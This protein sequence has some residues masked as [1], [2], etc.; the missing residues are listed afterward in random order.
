MGNGWWLSA[1]RKRARRAIIASQV[2]FLGITIKTA[3]AE[4]GGR[5][6]TKLVPSAEADSAGSTFAFPVL[7]CRAFRCRR[8]AAG[9][10]F[11]PLSRSIEFR[12]NRFDLGFRK[13][14]KRIGVAHS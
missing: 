13:F 4:F 12:N 3:S 7:P 11:V 9:A 8:Y 5:K 2:R 1:I 6:V 10:E 14:L